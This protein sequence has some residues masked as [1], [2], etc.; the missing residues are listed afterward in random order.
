M[1]DALFRL[2]RPIGADD[3][4]NSPVTLLTAGVSEYP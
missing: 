2:P 4:H 1:M 3:G